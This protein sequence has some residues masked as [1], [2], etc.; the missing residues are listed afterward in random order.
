MKPHKLTLSCYLKKVIMKNTTILTFLLMTFTIA[1]CSSCKKNVDT[2]AD[3]TYGLPNATQEGKNTLGFLLNG[4]PWT[5]KGQVG[6][7][8]NLTVSVDFGYNQGVFG[9]TAYR[10]NSNNTR[11]YFGFGIRDSLNFISSP[12][13]ILLTSK[14]LFQASFSNSVC[15]TDYYDMAIYR[16]GNLY[17][18]KLDKVNRIIAGA[19]NITLFKA[20]CPDT[21]KITEGRFDMK[22]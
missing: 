11:D 7:S 3:N 9:I 20:G 6:V 13:N 16:S 8:A 4:Q 5:P 18:T 15:Q 22:F 14:S 21:I 10:V 2:A 1:G 17:I 12:S 19:F